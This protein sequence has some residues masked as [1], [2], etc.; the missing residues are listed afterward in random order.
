MKNK[1]KK[2][3]EVAQWW[4]S[5]IFYSIGYRRRTTT[6]VIPSSLPFGRKQKCNFNSRSYSKL[7]MSELFG[8]RSYMLARKHP[9]LTKI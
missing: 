2:N 6:Q 9:P 7:R 1:T 8:L 3:L 5:C 4:E